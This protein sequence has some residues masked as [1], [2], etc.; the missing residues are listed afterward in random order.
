[1]KKIE[2]TVLG[3][4]WQPNFDICIPAQKEQAIEESEMDQSD[5]K[6]FSDGSCIGGHVCAAAVL[7]RNGEESH[8]SDYTW[9]L[10]MNTQT[11]KWN[12][13]ELQSPP[14]Y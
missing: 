13:Q 12:L 2:T 8:V 9:A 7:Y 3:P 10:K 14:N 11:L 6:I 4:K 1:M 5:I